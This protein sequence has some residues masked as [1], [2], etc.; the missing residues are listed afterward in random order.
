MGFSQEDADAFY[1]FTINAAVAADI[2][3]MT[4]EEIALYKIL[5]P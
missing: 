1:Y 2:H 5:T 3:W 4:D